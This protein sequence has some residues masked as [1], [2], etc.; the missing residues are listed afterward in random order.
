MAE[1]QSDSPAEPRRNPP[2]PLLETLTRDTLDPGYAEAAARSRRR[3]A[4]PIPPRVTIAW[5][6][7][8]VVAVGALFGIAA[9]ETGA[10]APS[11]ERVRA[12]LLD[13]IDRAQARAVVMEESV[14][15]LADEIR[16]A[17]ESLG[18]AG[19]L[20]RVSRLEQAAAATPVTGPGL[21]IVIDAGESGHILDRDIQVLVNGLWQAGAEAVAVGTVRLRGTSAIRQAGGSILVDNKPVFWPITVEAIGSPTEFAGQFALTGG[22]GR[23]RSFAQLYGIRFDV[24]ALD[25]LTLPAASSPD[26]RYASIP[27]TV[28]TGRQETSTA[29]SSATSPTPS[30]V[31]SSTR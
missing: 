7:A 19:P 14:S 4:A 29:P 17:Q 16:S 21:R 9:R 28:T 25:T 23:F 26:I 20:A 30:P 8:G 22:Y 15:A 11:A 18:A 1:P 27:T 3:H 31:P 13:D 24:D 6:L 5:L 10:Q 12:G 2:P